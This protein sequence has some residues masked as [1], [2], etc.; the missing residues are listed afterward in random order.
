M[1]EV[2]V[3]DRVKV[4]S[5]ESVSTAGLRRRILHVSPPF[6]LARTVAPAWWAH[7]RWPNVDWRDG[8][9]FWVGWE[10]GNVAW[11]SVRQ[12]D[13]SHLEI[14]G[15][16]SPCL[17]AEWAPAVLGTRAMMPRFEDAVLAMLAGAHA[18]LRPWASGSLFTGIVTSIVGQSIS[19]AAAATAERRL[20][21]L[22]N[23]P[24]DVGG[25]LYWPSPRPEQLSA[26]SVELVRNSG[27]T[28]KRAAALVAVATLFATGAVVEC[29]NM[30]SMGPSDSD[31]LL[32]IPGIGPWTVRSAM[33][34]GIGG[35]DSHPT[36]D[37]AL[38]RAAKLH[39]TSVIGLKD[40]DRLS[41]TWTP[42]RGWAARLL[43]LD[44]LGF[45]SEDR[46]EG[47]SHISPK[48]NPT[49]DRSGPSRRPAITGQTR[50]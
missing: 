2:S 21:A 40:L 27:V 37:V 29:A 18:G 1:P 24:I 5:G 28:T 30:E 47:A 49:Q 6:D 4:D 8:A 39:Y 12:G 48:I 19:V 38:L 46:K 15:A 25:R 17:D 10:D 44:L 33:L 41:E 36:G 32:A 34:W 14:Q 20:F 9:F 45:E 23:E 31:L 26:A 3:R 50:P 11:R 43:W 42:H 22:F 35:D 13:A 7:G 16:S